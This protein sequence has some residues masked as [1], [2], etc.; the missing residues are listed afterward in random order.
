MK[1]KKRRVITVIIA[2]DHVLYK[3]AV[4]N[5][6]SFK[7]DIDVIA[8]AKNGSHLL[9]LLNTVQPDVI[10]LDIQMP[11]MDGIVT[12]PEV[13]K[14]YP[15]I[16]VIMLSML[17]D[18]RMI[19]KLMELGASSYLIKTSNP[20]II[21]EAIKACY[22]EGFYVNS[23]TNP[24]QPYHLQPDTAAPVNTGIKSPILSE[25]EITVLRLI[26]EE[27]SSREIAEMFE[28][29]IGAIEAIKDKLKTKTGTKGIAGLIR[30]AV[31]N[32]ILHEAT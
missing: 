10:L 27:K 31:K 23:L 3:S 20:E 6:L 1:I 19:T 15:D 28:L 16:K 30:F 17:D 5:A 2:D 11:V 13:K 24:L 9:S 29:S 7:K 22:E 8:E 12:L 26:C 4:K 21:Y 18:Q 14:L 32:N 25:K